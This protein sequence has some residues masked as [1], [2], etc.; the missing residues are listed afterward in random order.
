[1]FGNPSDNSSFDSDFLKLV[2]DSVKDIITVGIDDLRPFST[3][4]Y[5][6]RGVTFSARKFPR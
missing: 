6:P 5:L 4:W 3:G 1:M 2:N